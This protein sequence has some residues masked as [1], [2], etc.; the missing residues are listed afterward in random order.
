MDVLTLSGILGHTQVATTEAFYL[1][2]RQAAMHRAMAR[3]APV[4]AA[5]CPPAPKE[6]PAAVR[7]VPRKA[8]RPGEG[9]A[10]AAAVR[11]IPREKRKHK[12][13]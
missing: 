7:V 8:H 12:G 11:K 2:P 10:C 6:P 4:D 5:A 9:K 1:H 3:V 13:A